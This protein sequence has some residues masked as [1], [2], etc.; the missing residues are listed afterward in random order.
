MSKVLLYSAYY[1][2]KQHVALITLIVSIVSSCCCWVDSAS[3]S[4]SHT[5]CLIRIFF[6]LCLQGFDGLFLN[7]TSTDLGTSAAADIAVTFDSLQSGAAQW[8][9]LW[10]IECYS[11]NKIAFFNIGY[12][13]YL[14]RC[15]SCYKNAEAKFTDSA[16]VHVNGIDSSTPYAYWRFT[17]VVS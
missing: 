14:T 1:R 16:W 17:Q 6:A 3:A 8:G 5:E 4:I 10:R 12:R 15:Q 9:A 2:E 7:A 13:Q 11:S